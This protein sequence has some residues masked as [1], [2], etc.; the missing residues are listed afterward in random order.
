M[1]G[2]A[3]SEYLNFGTDQRST[4]PVRMIVKEPEGT[5]IPYAF[6]YPGEEDKNASEVLEIASD[7][8]SVSGY[9]LVSRN[10]APDGTIT[11]VTE[12]KG[13]DDRRGVN[14]RFT[15][16]LSA[17]RFVVRKDVEGD[18]GVYFNRNEY[19]LTR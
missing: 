9:A 11:L 16:E 3:S 5:S 2:K 18:N 19:R 7:G 13:D 10:V 4:I 1:A 6:L 12:G 15:Y 14:V 8:R 17:N